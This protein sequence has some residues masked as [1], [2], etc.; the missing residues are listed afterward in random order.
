MQD[1]DEQQNRSTKG[2][3]EKNGGRKGRPRAGAGRPAQ[4]RKPWISEATSG[5]RPPAPPTMVA[6]AVASAARNP[7]VGRAGLAGRVGW[8]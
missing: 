4:V 8:R 6:L 3:E 2:E 7:E 5:S 1:Q